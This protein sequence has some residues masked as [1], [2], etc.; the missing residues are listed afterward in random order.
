MR[1]CQK[2]RETRGLKVRG[3][4]RQEKR[5]E[6]ERKIKKRGARLPGGDAA[7]VAR[8]RGVGDEHLHLRLYNFSFVFVSV[9]FTSRMMVH[10][11]RVRE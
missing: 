11:S 6:L 8:K 5:R 1:G 10:R 3:A 7:R 9:G 4:R 2:A